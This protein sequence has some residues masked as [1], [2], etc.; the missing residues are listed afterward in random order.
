M[1]CGS[2]Y[3]VV[4]FQ[5]GSSLGGYGPGYL[6][7]NG[8][9]L[10]VNTVCIDQA[11][12]IFITSL[13]SLYPGA[14]VEM[15]RNHIFSASHTHYAPMVDS[16]KPAV[17]SYDPEAVEMWKDA[18]EEVPSNLHWA[19]IEKVV[20]YEASV[21]FPVYRRYDSKKSLFGKLINP[22]IGMYPNTTEPVDRSIKVFIFFGSDSE[23]SFCIVWHCCHPVTRPSREYISADYVGAIRHQIRDRFGDIPVLFFLGPSGD[24][25]P[26]ISRKRFEFLPNLFINRRFASSPSHDESACIDLTYKQAIKF[27]TE[28]KVVMHPKIDIKPLGCSLSNGNFFKSFRLSVSELFDFLFMPFEVSHR[29]HPEALS[30]GEL[31]VSC[32]NSVK[33]YLPHISQIAYGGYEVDSSRKIMNY[34]E[35]RFYLRKVL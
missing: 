22:L 15:F 24:I 12:N 33:G 5:K 17:G 31:L 32:S 18:I 20:Q 28:S 13:D 9:S 34:G 8:G 4:N 30:H 25:R 19:H 14:L 26:Y 35:R 16:L 23:A 1:I 2:A 3:S 11:K 21:P 7:L 27:M 6:S 29:Y 10:E